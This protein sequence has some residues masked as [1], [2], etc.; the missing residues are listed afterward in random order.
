MKPSFV[1]FWFLSVAS[2]ADP[3]SERM[4]YFCK[5]L[6]VKTFERSATEMFL[7]GLRGAKNFSDTFQNPL[8]RGQSRKIRFTKFPGVRTEENLVNSVFCWFS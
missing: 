1:P 7:S 3:R 6:A 8:D 4:F 5:F 2:P